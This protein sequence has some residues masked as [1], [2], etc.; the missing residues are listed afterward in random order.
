MIW[1][2]V[3]RRHMTVKWDIGHWTVYGGLYTNH[4]GQRARSSDT[5]DCAIVYS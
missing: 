3:G 4:M 5:C 1:D 2:M